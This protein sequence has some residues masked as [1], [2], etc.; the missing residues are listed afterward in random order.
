M[1]KIWTYY[2]IIIIL[3]DYLMDIIIHDYKN[4]NILDELSYVLNNKIF[5]NSFQYIVYIDE[6][7]LICNKYNN[8]KDII[9]IKNI[10]LHI[11]NKM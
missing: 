11:R 9:I 5:K 8:N 7:I 4:S 10:L 2:D 3:L 6:M 1:E